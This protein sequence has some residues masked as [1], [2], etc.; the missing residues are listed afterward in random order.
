MTAIAHIGLPTLGK[1]GSSRLRV[2]LPAQLT[3]MHGTI[4]ATLLDL[5]AT[6]AKVCVEAPVRAGNDMMLKWGSF[7]AFGSVVWVIGDEA[8]L[9]FEEPVSSEILLE[10]RA[11]PPA[12]SAADIALTA[13]W[14]FVWG[15]GAGRVRHI[16]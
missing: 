2:R 9:L 7:E 14:N 10:T 15:D 11:M 6:G 13:A 1:R 5:S 8:G 16:R 12:S 4:R 3:A